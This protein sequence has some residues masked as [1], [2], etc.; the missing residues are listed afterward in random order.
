V[1][2]RQPLQQLASF[3]RPPAELLELLLVTLS[4]L[5]A[6]IDELVTLEEPA[7]G[8]KTM[9]TTTAMIEML[10]NITDTPHGPHRTSRR[11]RLLGIGGF[12]GQADHRRLRAHAR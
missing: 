1:D 6:T 8:P 12:A 2:V 7:R 4:L 3:C 11:P 10:N 9:A 5:L